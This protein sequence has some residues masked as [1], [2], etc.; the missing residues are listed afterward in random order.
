MESQRSRRRDPEASSPASATPH[1]RRL[2]LTVVGVVLAA[3]LLTGGPWVLSRVLSDTAEE[4][5]ALSS[6]VEQPATDPD[7]PI[8]L[9]GTWTIAEG[10]Q[11]GYRI[12]EV[13]AGDEVE[14]VGR[15][16]QVSGS[17]T[18]SDGELVAA[19]AV[20]QVAGI[21]TDQS[22][23]DVYFQ[24]ALDTTTYPEAT[25]S[26]T[27]PVDVAEVGTSTEPVTVEAVGELTIGG[28]AVDVTAQLEVQRTDA[29]LEVAGQVPVELTDLGL[30]APDL[31][32]VTVS[33]D[34][35]I[36]MLLIL[37]S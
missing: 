13:L 1:R 36:E 32:F 20:V 30:T 27:E 14:V 8:D 4:P 21:T 9:E 35:S 26:L 19:E 5:L 17:A 33:S 18:I 6:A 31:G 11:A 37:T 34:A 29:G 24:R 25:F 12:D 22:A 7:E 2:V 15:T 28:T 3:V 16:D 10:S 23:R